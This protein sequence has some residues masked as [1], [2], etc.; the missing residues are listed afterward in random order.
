MQLTIL[1]D[2]LCKE[3]GTIKADHLGEQLTVNTRKELCGA[4]VNIMNVTFVNY[5]RKPPE[6]EGDSER[7]RNI[8]CCQQVLQS[9]KT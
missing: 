2:E 9:D 6:K 3:M 4:F 7:F 1:S 8:S 5:T